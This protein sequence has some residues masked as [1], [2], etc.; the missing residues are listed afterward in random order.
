[1]RY[2]KILAG[3]IALGLVVY[4]MLPWT[5]EKYWLPCLWS[6]TVLGGFAIWPTRVQR[7]TGIHAGTQNLAFVLLIGFTMLTVQLL[8]I[9]VVK[10]D[11]IYNRSASDDVGNITSNPRLARASLRVQ[12]GTIFDAQGTVLAENALTEGGLSY[13]TY[14]IAN[15]ADIRAFS[16]ILG[17]VSVTYGL[18]GI[19]DTYDEYLSGR[20]G[21]SWQNLQNDIFDRPQTGNNLQLTINADLQNSAYQALDGRIGSVV[22]MDVQ[23]GAIRALV[24]NPGFDPQQLTL[25]TGADDWGAES[26]RIQEYWQSLL[27]NEARPLVHRATTGLYPPGST[28][29]TVTAVGVLNN[30]DVGK[31]E[32]ITC[33]NRFEADPQ[34]SA[35]FAVRNAVENEEQ[36]IAGKYGAK[37][38]LDGVYAFSCNTAFAQYGLR[39]QS[40][41]R[42][43]LAEQA[44]RFHVYTPG[45]LPDEGD[46]TDLPSFPSQLYSGEDGEDWWQ[47]P[48]A[49][50]DTSFGQGRLQVTPLVMGQIAQAIGNNGTMMKPYLVERIT[51]NDGRELYKAKPKVIGEPLTPQVAQRMHQA[52]RAV[53]E[54]G[55]PGAVAAGVPG[56]VVGG[57]S[58]TA[59]NPQGIPHAWFISIAPLEAPKYAVAVMI[60]NGG[61]GTS[62]GG[63]LAGQVMAAALE[64]AP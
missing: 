47:R 32:D 46:L 17:F 49:V 12:R 24:S 5:A 25:N 28:F 60:E 15:S 61:E 44:E 57:K 30:P 45:N 26:T 43:A 11:D 8:R 33:P 20:K 38:G 14:P 54:G 64:I 42:N 6:A 37:Y 55:W 10:A 39:L 21:N 59:E 41:N 13:R 2:L 29:K 16:H 1:M 31:P 52:M 48:A 34:V 63:G 53:I 35:E 51:S 56:V 62:V 50:A 4:G 19:E 22:V 27:A 7:A 3:L 40:D 18:A 9:Q 36:Y 23:T 58:G